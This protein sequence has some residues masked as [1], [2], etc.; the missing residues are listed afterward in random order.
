MPRDVDAG[1]GAIPGITLY[2][3]DTL[4]AE[5]HRG[6]SL[7]RYW[8]FWMIIWAVSTSGTTIG[9]ASPAI[10]N[11][12]E[13]ITERVLTYP[14]LEDGLEQ[15]EL[16]ELTVSK[17]VD[18]LTGGLKEHFTPE[19]LERVV[20]KIKVHTAVRSRERRIAMEKNA[21]CFPLF[22]D[23]YGRRCVIVGGGAIATRRAAVLGEFG[24]AVTVIAPEWKGGVR[25]IDWVPRVYVPGD[26]AGAFL[27]VAAT[28]D[29]EVNRSVGEEARKLGIPRQR[30]G[31]PGGVH[32][33]FPAVCEHG[34][35]TVGLVSHSGGDHRRAAEAA[36][37]VRKALR[38]WIEE[39]QS[40]KPGEPSG[41]CSD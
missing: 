40:G 18:L 12:K 14:E 33:L 35:V 41:R 21:S 26:L 25:N 24:A 9:N 19:D 31:S 29:R 30:G 39:T 15:E 36:S 16:V 7:W 4:G 2:N 11:L 20:G 8:I 1:V 17:A 28:D 34:G 10:E 32:L 27:A 5:Q 38:N 23:L 22:V 37:A 13:A 6:R 3:V